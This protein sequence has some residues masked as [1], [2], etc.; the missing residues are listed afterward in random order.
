MAVKINILAVELTLNL[1][2]GSYVSVQRSKAFG[3]WIMTP[4]NLRVLEVSVTEFFEGG[5][6]VC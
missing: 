3:V 5:E 6:G 1:L 4:V 2:T